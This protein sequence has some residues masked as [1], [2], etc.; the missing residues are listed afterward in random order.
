[1]AATTL[2]PEVSEYIRK[3]LLSVKKTKRLTV[4]QLARIAGYHHM[5]LRRVLYNNANIG[6]AQLYNVSQY[7]NLPMD[8]WFPPCTE[9]VE[10]KLI[11]LKRQLILLSIKYPDLLQCLVSLAVYL[12]AV[13]GATRQK[14]VS[15]VRVFVQ[16]TRRPA[17]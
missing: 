6:M 16:Q 1:M 7:F 11:P 12:S 2:H 8:F 13:D 10:G 3:Q 4:K 9:V 5:S 14:V 17:P 15:V